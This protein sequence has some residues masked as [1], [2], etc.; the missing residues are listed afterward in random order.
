M[1]YWMLIKIIATSM[2]RLVSTTLSDKY[3]FQY[4]MNITCS[5][6]WK[7]RF[8]P[9]KTSWTHDVTHN[10]IIINILVEYWS[11][12]VFNRQIILPS[13]GELIY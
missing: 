7:T 11:K 5:S 9:I 1:N 3:L 13:S 12:S 4:F 10:P 2:F 6:V 8:S